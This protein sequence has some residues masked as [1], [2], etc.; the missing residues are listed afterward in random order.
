MT[1][2]DLDAAVT[3][4]WFPLML[5]LVLGL[6]LLGLWFS[7]RKQLGRID[8]PVDSQHPEAGPFAKP[9]A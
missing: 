9:G 7:M 1:L 3:P 6:A 8:V 2:F 5:V 4:G